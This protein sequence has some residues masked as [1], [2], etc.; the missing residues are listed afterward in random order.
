LIDGF[1]MLLTYGGATVY[2][3]LFT[4]HLS[5]FLAPSSFF[6]CAA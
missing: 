1:A 4:Y 6:P 3:S 5:L 2:L